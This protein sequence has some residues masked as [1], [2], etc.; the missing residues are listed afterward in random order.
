MANAD[1]RLPPVLVLPDI[2][3]NGPVVRL[4]K[5]VA[6]G[7]NL[8]VTIANEHER[9]ML[10]SLLDGDAYLRKSLS[11]KHF[12]DINR[13]WRKLETTGRL[14]YNIARQSKD[15]HLRMEEFLQLE[16]SGW[17]GRE[18]TAMAVDRYRA[19]F[20][21]EAIHNLAS[22]DKV[23]IHTLDFDG[24]AI[25][26][27][28]VFV[29]AGEAYTWKTAYD[30]AFAPYSPGKM[31]T[32]KVTDWH[33]DD[34][35]IIRTDSCAAPDHPIMSRMWL[36]RD[37]IGTLI[38]GLQPNRDRDVRQVAAQLHLYQNTRN[39]ARMLRNRIMA[40]RRR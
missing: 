24:K 27:L 36:E 20:A 8:S 34:A 31:L 2:R 39:A 33:L 38:I 12:H 30:E 13:L 22:A 35:N 14:G 1:S 17:K 28:I 5:A 25:A 26:S 6:L 11:A 16:A 21:R 4:I 7:R 10:E 29:S 19:A 32:A 37:T 40:L 15:V 3:V 18:K 23:R 9:P